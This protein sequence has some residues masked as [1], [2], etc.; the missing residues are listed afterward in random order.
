MLQVGDSY[1]FGVMI[2]HNRQPLP[3]YGSCIF[4]HVWSRDHS[5]TAGCTAIDL[6]DLVRLLHWLDS[7]KNP[8]IVQLPVPEYLRLRPGW[9]LP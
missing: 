4:L 3:G 9:G 1:R 5:G 7:R 6:S 8:L 2:E